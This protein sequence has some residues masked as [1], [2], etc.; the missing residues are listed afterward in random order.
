MKLAPSDVLDLWLIYICFSWIFKCQNRTKKSL[1]WEINK[2]FTRHRST[3]SAP[4]C[5]VA[6]FLTD[7]ILLSQRPS[8]DGVKSLSCCLCISGSAGLLSVQKAASSSSIPASSPPP[9]RC[10]PSRSPATDSP[11][12]RGAAAAPRS[13]EIA[14]K[15]SYSKF[16]GLLFGGLERCV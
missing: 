4:S 9:S 10:R 16:A 5:R 15:V 14:V 2:L 12:G 7:R 6:A 11:R 13:R 1:E 3:F 8:G